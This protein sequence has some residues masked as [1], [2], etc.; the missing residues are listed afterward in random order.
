MTFQTFKNMEDILPADQFCRIHKSYIVSLKKIDKIERNQV[1]V[2]GERLPTGE[3]Y[4]KT[5]FD[6]LKRLSIFHLK[7][8]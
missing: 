3:T 4:R 7:A 5:F 6:L 1:I 2:K 8:F